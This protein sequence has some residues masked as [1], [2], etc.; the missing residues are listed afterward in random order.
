[1]TARFLK[2][3]VKALWAPPAPS[4]PDD[5]RGWNDDWQVGDLALCIDPLLT[6]KIGVG[7]GAARPVCGRIYR[8][9][10]LFEGVNKSGT[11]LLSGLMFVGLP[12]GL[13][14]HCSS[15]RKIRPDVAADEIETGLVAKIKRAAKGGRGVMA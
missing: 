14:W 2:G 15:F 12:T 3:L 4:A 7:S 8:V 11:A 9:S 5:R 10:G 13:A 6:G 1:M